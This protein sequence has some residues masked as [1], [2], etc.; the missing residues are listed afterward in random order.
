[1]GMKMKQVS[2]HCFATLNE[3]NRVKAIES[4]YKHK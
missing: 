3:K 1:M 4:L 2:E